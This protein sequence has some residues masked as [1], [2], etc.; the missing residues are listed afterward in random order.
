[1]LVDAQAFQNYFELITTTEAFKNLSQEKLGL[2]VSRDGLNVS[3][4]QTVVQSLEIWVSADPEERT[5][6]LLDLLPF[7]RASFL[8]SQSVADLKKFLVN[9]SQP[10]LC[11]KLNFDNKTPRQGYV[12]CIVAVHEKEGGSCLKYLDTKVGCNL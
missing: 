7:I 5:E 9:H 8:S 4:E 10:N 3:E 12:Q 11:H 2:L 1:M 6:C